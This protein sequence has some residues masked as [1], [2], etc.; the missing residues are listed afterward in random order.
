LVIVPAKTATNTI[1]LQNLT[2]STYNLVS[3]AVITDYTLR[4]LVGVSS[5]P[6]SN[7]KMYPNGTYKPVGVLQRHG[8]S[9]RMYFGLLTGS[10]TKNLS[11]GVLRQ[12]IGSIRPEI[13]QTTGDSDT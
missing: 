3:N 12:P 1:G 8:E 9:E 5:M 11:G 13:D 7:C 6:E 10:Y 4:V 2:L